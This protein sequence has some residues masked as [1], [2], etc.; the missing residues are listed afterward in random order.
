MADMIPGELGPTRRDL[1][2]D[3]SMEWILTSQKRFRHKTSEIGHNGRAYSEHVMEGDVF[4]HCHNQRDLGFNGLFNRG[5]SLVSRYIDR[6]GIRLELFRCLCVLMSGSWSV[7]KGTTGQNKPSEPWGAPEG[8]GVL[9][10]G[11]AS[12]RQQCW[13]PKRWSLWHSPW[14]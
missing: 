11:Q 13:S 1:D 8:R 10:S 3:F 14:P 9:R 12:R 2:C 6:S 4:C 7:R 5:C